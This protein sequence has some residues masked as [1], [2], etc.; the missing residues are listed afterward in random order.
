[1]TGIIILAAG[2]SSRLGQPKQLVPWRGIPLIRHAAITAIKA[3]LGPVVVVL[4]A[5]EESCREV[6]ED[7]D[8]IITGNLEWESGMGS[9]ISCGVAA[10][11]SHD[12]EGLEN[13]IVTLCD[14][15]LITPEILQKLSAQR[16]S[17]R[18]EVV[19][20]HNGTSWA[21]P[22]LFSRKRFPLLESLTGPEGARSLL[23][24]EPSI[25]SVD[26]PES[27]ADIDTPDDLAN[28]E[29]W[30]YH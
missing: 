21:P 25:T 9:S 14:L 3:R 1:M 19:A 5:V 13:V 22:I 8:L 18:T 20:C 11:A 24:D 16:H 15:P 12:S 29:A 17:E 28:A 26:C 27:N 30:P 2:S 10:L 23:R 7:L 4:G 6:L